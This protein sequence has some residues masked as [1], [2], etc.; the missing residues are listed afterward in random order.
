MFMLETNAARKIW[1]LAA[2]HA[3]RFS[4]FTMATRVYH[5]SPY[6]QQRKCCEEKRHSGDAKKAC[7]RMPAR[8]NFKSYH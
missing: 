3:H 7:L 1:L 5:F 6:K 4:I 2:I 8:C